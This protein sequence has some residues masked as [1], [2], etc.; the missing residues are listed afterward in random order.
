MTGHATCADGQMFSLQLNE[1]ATYQKAICRV[2]RVKTAMNQN[3]M[4]TTGKE[5]T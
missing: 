2:S 1:M 5:L 4:I 3:F